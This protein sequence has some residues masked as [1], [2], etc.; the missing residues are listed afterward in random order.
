[1]R[2]FVTS[3]TG[4]IGFAV[5]KQ[6][7]AAGHEV[8]GLARSEAST[9]KLSAAG[10]RVQVGTVDDLGCLRRSASAA[11]GVIHT[12]YYH[13]LSHMPLGALAGVFLGG[14]PGGIIKRFMGGAVA[15]DRRAIKT[16]GAWAHP[17]VCGLSADRVDCW[18]NHSGLP[19]AGNG[20]L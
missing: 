12:A 11:E 8:T 6:L 20:A 17:K 2:V 3:A 10:A 9:K 7:A 13:K 1:M 15:T 4:L 16:M 14:P 5:V 19:A 18:T